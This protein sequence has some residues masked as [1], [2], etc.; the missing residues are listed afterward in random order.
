[1]VLFEWYMETIRVHAYG[2][3]GCIMIVEVD[4]GLKIESWIRM[5]LRKSQNLP[6]ILPELKD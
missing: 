6:K 3:F 5:Q 4:N 2:W 1:M